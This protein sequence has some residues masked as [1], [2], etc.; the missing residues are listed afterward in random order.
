MHALIVTQLVTY[1]RFANR[2][3]AGL[4]SIKF[5][6]NKYKL[7]LKKD[8]VLGNEIERLKKM[9]YELY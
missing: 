4:A 3:E 7:D 8:K 1:N 9:I 5:K 6:E 2:A